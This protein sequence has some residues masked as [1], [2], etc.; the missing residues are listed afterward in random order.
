[1]RNARRAWLA[2]LV[3]GCTT[4]PPANDAA[5]IDDGGP[6]DASLDAPLC[7]PPDPFP[8][9]MPDGHAMP[10]GAAAHQVR[11]G[12]IHTADLPPDPDGLRTWRDGDYVLANDHLAF[13]VSQ[14]GNQEI[15]DPYGGR[16]RGLARV[17]GGALVHPADF[18]LAMLGVSRFVVATDSVSVMNDGS[19][20]QPAIVRVRGPLAGIE[21]LGPLLET[22]IRTDLMDYPAALDYVLA[23]DDDGIE[24]R[25][26]VRR[27]SSA[28]VLTVPFATSAFFQSF[29]MPS[30]T[31]SGGFTPATE[32]VR[33]VAFEDEDATSYA[34]SAARL[35][36]GSAGVVSP[37][38]STG[39]FDF[40][41]SP[42]T[43]FAPCTEHTFVL[44]RF[45][46]G[47][48]DGLNGVQRVLW[49]ELGEATRTLTGTVTSADAAA[50]AG[51]HLHV[52]DAAGTT[53]FTRATIDATGAFSLVVP[54]AAASVWV[55]REGA[56]M[57]GPFAIPASGPMTIPLASLATVSVDVTD[58]STAMPLP[59]RVQLFP[60][61]AMPPVAPEAFGERVLG[62]GRSRMEFAP[63]GGHVDLRVA[64][65]TYRLVVSH[66][67]EMEIH[68]ATFTLAAGDVHPV[69]AALVRALDTPGV[70]CADY[71][72]HTHRS[73]D[74]EDTGTLKVSALAA[75]GLEIAIRSEH[76]WVDDFGPVVT[77]L[78]LEDHVVGLAG[79]ELTTFTYGHFGVF[80]LVVD[81]TR[82]SN[83]ATSW[84][85]RFAPD[86]FDEVRAR[87]ES[88]LLIINHPRANGVRQGYFRETGYDPATG[89]VAHPENW[90]TEFDV[91]EVIN[92]SSFDSNRGSGGSGTVED[93][94][95]LLHAGRH[96]MMVGSS[97]SHH[98]HGDPVGYPRTCLWIGTD[99]IHA[100][101]GDMVRDVTRAGASYVMGGI[102]LDVM[103]PGSTRPGHTASGVGMRT[104]IHVTVSAASFVD[105]D[106]LEVI[107][108]G[109]STETLPI[110]APIDPTDPVRFDDVVE[111]DVAA[112]GSFVVLHAYGNTTPNIAYGDQPF[113]VS[114]PIFLTR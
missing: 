36:D 63:V 86:V 66:G 73:V 8:I 24:V 79:E 54:T 23:P 112:A 95:S 62:R 16:V 106:A 28:R 97:D 39:G 81:R 98:T 80:P 107:V 29:R 22:L 61:G 40:Y 68:D 46:V 41:T 72:I 6:S 25:L 75:D 38:Y 58:A 1:M 42:G 111:V 2:L 90:D 13:V 109:T 74:S 57:E 9:G 26:S 55:W 99:D 101:T 11:A 83:G 56:P 96:V 5:S 89:M 53:H 110:P 104:Q 3:L 10:L 4:P 12:R 64:P 100:V 91:V 49:R 69:A 59:A 77:R 34:W 43:S 30:W 18:N 87:A 92:S 94:Y 19:D 50:I 108:D 71:H 35:P 17:S 20:G 15:Y 32:D 102:Y 44:G 33:F 7:A 14:P 47:E 48:T 93:W 88:P 78:G 67:W 103:G 45:V 51:A 113:A 70:M 27:G 105:V 60:V 65:G 76:E 31:E 52:T 82:P 85:H 37:F 114:N 21:A 84:F